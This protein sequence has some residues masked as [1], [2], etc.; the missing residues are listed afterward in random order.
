MKD[1]QELDIKMT[2]DEI[3]LMKK[4]SLANILNKAIED[5]ALKDLNQIKIKHSNVLHLKH[6]YMKMKKYLMPNKMK[7]TRD[8]IQLIF[9]LRSRL[10]NI[11]KNYECIIIWNSVLLGRRR[12]ENSKYW[13]VQF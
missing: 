11:K 13:N 2:F 10:T 5:K 1:I 3:K 8:E 12:R 4:S 6:D 7:T 9:K